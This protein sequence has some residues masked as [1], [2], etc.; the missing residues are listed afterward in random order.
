VYQI[1]YSSQPFFRAQFEPELKFPRHLT[2]FS[3]SAR[4]GDNGMFLAVYT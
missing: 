2:G 4:R 1:N 3:P